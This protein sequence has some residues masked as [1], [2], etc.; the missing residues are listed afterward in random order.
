MALTTGIDKIIDD[1][2]KETKISV[3]E[4]TALTSLISKIMTHIITNGVVVGACPSGG[5]PLTGGKIE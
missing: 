3:K 2:A 1:Y 5:G 4:K